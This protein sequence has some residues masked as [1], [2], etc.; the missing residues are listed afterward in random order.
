[1][2]LLSK[3]FGKETPDLDAWTRAT[4][5]LILNSRLPDLDQK[6]WDLLPPEIVPRAKAQILPF[7]L[8]LFSVHFIQRAIWKNP[9]EIRSF[10]EEQLRMNVLR[11]FCFNQGLAQDEALQATEHLAQETQY[12]LRY[13]TASHRDEATPKADPYLQCI[14]K[15]VERSLGTVPA[16]DEKGPL[17]VGPYF[18]FTLGREIYSMDK[19]CLWRGKENR[20]ATEQLKKNSEVR[21]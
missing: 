18:L 7:R 2:R 1:V 21:P 8:T 15:Y 9:E 6:R 16:R 5:L 17:G 10:M 20:K 4:I 14:D 3:L 19:K 11:H 12:Y 13:L